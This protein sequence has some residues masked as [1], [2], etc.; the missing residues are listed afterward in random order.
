MTRARRWGLFAVCALT[1][2]ARIAQAGFPV[3]LRDDRGRVVR[4]PKAAKRVVVA[5][6]ALFAQILDEL[7]LAERIVGIAATPEAPERFASITRVGDVNAVSI[8]RTLALEPDL[9][10]G[11]FGPS[12][13]GLEA[14]GLLVYTPAPSD[15]LAGVLRTIDQVEI[16]VRGESSAAPGLVNRLSTE[17][18]AIESRVAGRPR[19]RVALLY[20]LPG[21][22]PLTAGAGTPDHELLAKAGAEN[23][24]A[25]PAGYHR[26][27]YEEILRSDPD[28]LVVDPSE[29]EWT[30]SH[31]V[32]SSLRAVKAG[33]VLAMR[34]SSWVSTRFP[35]TLR[36]LAVWLHPEAFADA[37]ATPAMPTP[38]AAPFSSPPPR[39][40]SGATP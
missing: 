12:R 29:L 39:P 38:A 3:E 37:G 1:L 8:E 28:A 19:P 15:D 25:A 33:R 30:R 18:A 20:P 26:V 9:V 14:A 22:P 17:V 24:F 35:D 16:A 13:D 23:V 5:G 6:P 40:T 7:G 31:E 11:A 34:P 4:I 36:T 2:G 10:L 21:S 27:S 32:V